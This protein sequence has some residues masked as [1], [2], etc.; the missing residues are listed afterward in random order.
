MPIVIEALVHALRDSMPHDYQNPING[1]IATRRA[2]RGRTASIDLSSPPILDGFVIVGKFHT[3]PNP[4]SEG[5]EPGPSERDR[6]VDE[7]H[8]VPD[9]IVS[10]RGYQFSGPER[11]RGG[12]LGPPGY[13]D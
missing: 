7:I 1:E 3:H 5:W 9:I 2:L 12:L 6:I 11:R 10:D 8:G 13:P 4:T